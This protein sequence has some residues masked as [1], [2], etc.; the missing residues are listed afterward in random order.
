[1]K[2]KIAFLFDKTNLW[3]ED[4]LNYF[5]FKKYRKKYF[6]KIFK[7]PR[8]IRNFDIVF[9]ISYTKI[10][11]ENFLKKNKLSLIPHPSKLPKDKGFAP[12]HNAVLK[13][14]KH[15]FIS[16]IRAEKEVDAGDIFLQLKYR[17]KG[18]ELMD[19]LRSIQ[20]K[21]VF[22]IISKFLDKYPKIKFKKQIGKSNFNKKRKPEDS[23]L[24]IKKS[25]LSQFNLLRVCDN[26]RYPAFFI[27]NGIKYIL[28]IEKDE[29]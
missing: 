22:E 13:G 9:V 8:K 20:A 6:I 5:N 16:L 10:L 26:Q 23:K 27:H 18:I 21:A 24:N 15:F 29:N 19:D 12:I 25:I 17:L 11:N 28:K 3:I 4:Y 7:E 1:M 14:K 2:K